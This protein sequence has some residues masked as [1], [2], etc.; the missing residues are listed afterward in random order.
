[1]HEADA[2]AGMGGLQ[3][4]S[5]RAGIRFQYHTMSQTDCFKAEVRYK[6]NCHSP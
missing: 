5:K 6:C 1:M 4:F 3:T 2:T